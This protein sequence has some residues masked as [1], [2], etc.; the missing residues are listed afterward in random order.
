MNQK[1]TGEL[2]EILNRAQTDEALQRYVSD[3]AGF[4]G[5]TFVDYFNSLLEKNGMGK[6]ELVAKTGIERTYLYQLLNG[7]RQPSRDYIL[8]LCIGAGLSLEQTTRCL[9]L[10]SE[11]V[12]YAKNA[13]DAIIIYSINRGY[14][15]NKT[16]ELLFDMEKEPLKVGREK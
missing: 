4:T 15:V 7:T 16:N 10:L 3:T 6:A 11:G 13:R 1:K 9:E 14:S 2:L 5:V 12:L 8:A